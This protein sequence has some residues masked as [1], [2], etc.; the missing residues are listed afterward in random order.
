LSWKTPRLPLSQTSVYQEGVQIK[1]D[2]VV[3]TDRNTREDGQKSSAYH[4]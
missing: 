3:H 4:V 1:L 2:R